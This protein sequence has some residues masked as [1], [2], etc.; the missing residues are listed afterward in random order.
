MSRRLAFG[1]ALF[2]VSL[3]PV[4]ALRA[5]GPTPVQYFYDD[6]GRLTA[7]GRPFVV[8]AVDF[9]FPWVPHSFAERKG[10][11]RDF[12]LAG[13]AAQLPRAMQEQCTGRSR[14]CFEAIWCGFADRLLVCKG[15]GFW[16]WLQQ[17]STK[18]G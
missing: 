18:L 3:A 2:V 9:G 17:R 7:G 12:A 10:A 16:S 14:G 1:F 15:R 6:L 11:S 13:R 4:R 8:G 5:Q